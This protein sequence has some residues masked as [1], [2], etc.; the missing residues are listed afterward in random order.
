MNKIKCPNCGK[1]IE[2]TEALSHQVREQIVDE[3]QKKFAHEITELN[4]KLDTAE[5]A[6]L[7]IR[8]QKNDFD[9]EKRHFEVEKQRQLDKERNLIR[10]KALEEQIEKDKYKFAELEKKIADT[11]KALEEANRKATQ[12]SQQSQGEVLELDLE[13]TLKNAIKTDIFEPVG[14]GVSGADIKQI[15]ITQ[16]GSTCGTIL[17]ESKRTKMWGNDW[18]SKLKT[19]MINAKANVA[20]IVSEML[21]DEAKAGMGQKDGIWVCSPKLVVPLAMLLHKAVEDTAR[22]KFI[23]NMRQTDAER[24]YNY[25][26]S[27]EFNQLAQSMLETYIEMDKQIAHE[28][29]AYEKIWKQREAQVTRLKLGVSGIMGQLQDAAGPA[30]PP[31]KNLELDTAE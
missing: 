12:G 3:E 24:V 25:V 6:E 22:Q 23:T 30:L 2:L 19:D 31:I 21:P 28:R 8:K 11:S 16:K 1:E 20:A 9:E 5:K 15:V 4:I 14:K 7:E 17:W 29:A 13:I 26:T 10:E 18:I 27:H